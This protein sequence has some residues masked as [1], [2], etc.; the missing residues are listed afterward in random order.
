MRQFQLKTAAA[1]AALALAPLAAQAGVVYDN[2]WNATG[3][4]CSFSTVCAAGAGRGDDFAAQQFSL[5]AAATLRSASFT[6]FDLGTTPTAANWAIY[7]DDGGLPAA[8]LVSGSANIA[9]SNDIASLW[10]YHISQNF[11]DLGAVNLGAGEYFFAVQG[12]SP[13]FETFLAFGT[14]GAG[15]A[16]THDGG[17]TWSQG[18]E[19]HPSVA[20]GLYDNGLGVPEP[21]TWALMIGGF[22]LA[23]AMLRRRS[24][25]AAAA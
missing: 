21:A 16:E 6:E 15:A 1:V 23:G 13:V 5:G 10:G 7:A 11:F 25:A 20:V 19:Y 4:D 3:G 18:Y 9:T 14:A 8:L 22:G 17:A 12:V 2:P 24:V